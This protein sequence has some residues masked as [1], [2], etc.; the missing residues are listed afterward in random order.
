M[1]AGCASGQEPILWL[2]YGRGD[3]SFALKNVKLY[4][5]DLDVSDQF[6]EMD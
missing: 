2:F 1:D 5:T 3:E 6:G 4:A